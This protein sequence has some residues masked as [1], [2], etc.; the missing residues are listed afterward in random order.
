VERK[1]QQLA[2]TS[3]RVKEFGFSKAVWDSC[4][5]DWKKAVGEGWEDK[6]ACI[7]LK[8]SPE[9]FLS[10]EMNVKA[11]DD[12]S[13]SASSQTGM[14][15]RRFYKKYGID[16]SRL[17]CLKNIYLVYIEKHVF[18]SEISDEQRELLEKLS[19]TMEYK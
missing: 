19:I 1:K 13:F 12:L 14:L 16:F 7:I 3:I 5:E 9:S 8:S 10:M 15:S 17:E 18:V 11:E 2:T 4:P 6:L